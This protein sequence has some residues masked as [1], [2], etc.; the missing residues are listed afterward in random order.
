MINNIYPDKLLILQLIFLGFQTGT[1]PSE[2]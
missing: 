2:E 1:N